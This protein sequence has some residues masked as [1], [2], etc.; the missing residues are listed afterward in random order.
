MS[1]EAKLIAYGVSALIFILLVGW[2]V[3]AVD[4]WHYDS[5]SL[6]D[7]KAR[8][9]VVQQQQQRV[10]DAQT[11]QKKAED[12]ATT[13]RQKLD[14]TN[15]VARDAALDSLHNV[16]S[17]VHTLAVRAS[18]ANPGAVQGRSAD[19]AGDR[20]LADQIGRLDAAA[21]GVD[22]AVGKAISAAQHDSANYTSI[23]SIEPK[24]V[25]EQ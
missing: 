10:I 6:A 8:D 18:V 14:A 15:T 16:Q 4:S 12:D 3:H 24:T 1:L 22:D 13:V 2:A 25:K 7:T 23:L 19:P 17:A 9:L 5:L 11:A 21:Q 20:E